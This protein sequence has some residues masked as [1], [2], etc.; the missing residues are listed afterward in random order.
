MQM[1]GDPRSDFA[2]GR[3]YNCQRCGQ[4]HLL[5]S[6]D[7]L[8]VSILP[9][10]PPGL[11]AITSHIIRKMQRGAPE[12]PLIDGSL[13]QKMWE[14]GDLPSPAQQAD[15]LIQLIAERKAPPGGFVSF[16]G[17]EL[18]GLLGTGDDGRTNQTEGV[19]FVVDH[20][21]ETGL[22]HW[23]SPADFRVRL[24]FPGWERLAAIERATI[25][26]RTAF[27]A[28]QFGDAE[29]EQ[30]VKTCFSRA[31]ERTRFT[32]RILTEAQPAGSI[33]DQLRVA[34][35]TSRFVIADLTHG[36]RGA[37]WEAGFAEGLG[38]PVIYSCKKAIWDLPESKPHF[39]TNHLQTILWDPA[40]LKT[41]EDR[42][43]AM[44]RATLPGEAKMDD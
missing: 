14:E 1:S 13:L 10:K 22:V 3:I 15:T 9:L 26:S 28:M 8:A 16:T 21:K 33:D 20:L 7:S 43:T 32:L 18:A 37:Y 17:D 23:Y 38:R 2:G 4:F 44:I 5:G 19:R 6:A 30:V 27:M 41:A 34:L 12:P 36:N 42:L 29:L 40:D 31:V 35:R 24:T 25:E 39:D 11:R